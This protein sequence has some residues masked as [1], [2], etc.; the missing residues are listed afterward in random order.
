[1]N[2]KL[3]YS[4][5]TNSYDKVKPAKVFPGF[6]YWLFSDN[7]D[8]NVAGWK[9][10]LINKDPNSILQQRLI[11]IKS[12][13]YTTGYDLTIYFDGNFE[14]IADPNKFLDNFYS[15]GI[16]IT[17][18]PK[19]NGIFE[20][21]REIVRKR[22]D[23]IEK[24]ELA[25]NYSKKVGY[26]DNLGLFETGFMVRDKSSETET[27]ER[28]WAEILEQTSHRDQLSLPIASFLTKVKIT[29]IP[30]S[31][32][33]QYLKFHRGHNFSLKFRSKPDRKHYLGFLDKIRGIYFQLFK[34]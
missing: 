20:E 14:L 18:H 12:F 29:T 21:A 25:L 34:K 3:I 26:K 13:L 5:V 7:K 32:T 11:K 16:L 27:L 8:L 17:K 15:G 24:V 19:R 31:V 23:A 30:R 4:V 6:D 1:M 22:K 2:N 28:K 33:Y 10:I 9:L